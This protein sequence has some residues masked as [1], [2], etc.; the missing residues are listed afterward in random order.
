[1]EYIFLDTESTGLGEKDRIIQLSYLAKDDKGMKLYEDYAS[2]DVEINIWAMVV[3]H[4][5]Q[6]KIA[7]CPALIDTESFKKLNEFN[8]PENLLIIHNSEFDLDML[9]KEGFE[10]KM[11]LIDTYIVLR[12]LHPKLDSHKLMYLWYL[13]ELQKADKSEY[14]K[15]LGKEIAPHDSSGD[16]VYL[17]MIFQYLLDSGVTIEKM[18]ELTNTRVLEY[19]LKFGKYRERGTPIEE[20]VAKDKKYVEWILNDFKDLS[21]D[22]R[23]TLEYWMKIKHGNR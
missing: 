3:H 19:K 4:I 8:I 2:T 21:E 5:T 20:V 6:E 7:S 1:M 16:V 23:Y 13:M 11:Q 12:H 9:K 18:I 22:L 15:I 14:E 10:N 17:S